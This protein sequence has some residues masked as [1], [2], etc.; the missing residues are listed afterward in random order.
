MLHSLDRIL[1]EYVMPQENNSPLT[2]YIDFQ[3]FLIF[4]DISS[5]VDQVKS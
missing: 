4:L 1:P 5:P 3:N 2:L